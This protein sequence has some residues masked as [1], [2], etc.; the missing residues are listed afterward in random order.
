MC[1]RL[2]EKGSDNVEFLY[3]PSIVDSVISQFSDCHVIV[4][5]DFNTGFGRQSSRTTIGPTRGFLSAV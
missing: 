4:G 3:Q 2:H 5:E 1:L